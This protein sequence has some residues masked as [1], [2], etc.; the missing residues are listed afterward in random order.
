MSGGEEP[1][2]LAA[3]TD[4]WTGD[5]QF[6]EFKP[7]VSLQVVWTIYMIGSVVYSGPSSRT[8]KIWTGNAAGGDVQPVE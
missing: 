2:Y 5:I 1:S 7:P 8:R 3:A 6:A 4:G